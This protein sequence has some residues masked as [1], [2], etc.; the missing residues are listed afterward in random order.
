MVFRKRRESE[1]ETDDTDTPT[2]RPTLRDDRMPTIPN[3][4][5]AVRAAIEENTTPNFEQM[6]RKDEIIARIMD[7]E[8]VEADMLNPYL[9]LGNPISF[10]QFKLKGTNFSYVYIH[11]NHRDPRMYI[12][13]MDED[14]VFDTREKVAIEHP[15]ATVLFRV[16]LDGTLIEIYRWKA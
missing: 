15:K 12:D 4:G 11:S 6:T 3:L 7:I 1:A 13:I 16:L 10:A 9:I 8:G 14:R 2:S 5:E